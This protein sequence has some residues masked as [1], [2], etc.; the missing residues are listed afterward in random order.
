[1]VSFASVIPVPSLC[2]LSPL[3]ALSA[4]SVALTFACSYKQVLEWLYRLGLVV[5]DEPSQNFYAHN[6]Y[7]HY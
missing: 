2:M 5:E 1:M 6:N 7:V 4:I 3:L